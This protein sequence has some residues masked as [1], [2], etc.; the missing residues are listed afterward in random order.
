M[1][2][3]D[4]RAVVTGG[5]QGIGKGIAIALAEE[6]A[7]IIIQYRNSQEQALGTIEDLKKLGRNA[8]AIQSDFT[9][10]SA[11]E[12][13]IATALKEFGALD[14]LVNCAAAYDRS[15]L[16]ELTHE[17]LAWMHK[18]NVEIPLRLI[19]S[20]SQH[21]IKRKLP[22]SIINISSIAG[23]KPNIGS[24]LIS[25]S[26][27]ALDMLTKCAALE[28]ASYQI[29]VNGIAPGM[30]DTESN[31]CYKETNPIGWQHA[32]DRIPLQRIGQPSDYAG[33][34]VFLA[35]EE[36]SWL[37]GVTINCDGGQLLG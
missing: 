24:T 23:F 28:L 19:Q 33:L 26:K 30:T 1:K 3:K 20:I 8:I 14:I 11:P 10:E 18:M 4:K 6:G 7:D 17:K 22:G 5:G 9:H 25:C 13:F 31:Q 34:A 32:I 21:F 27:A 16:L 12:K 29:R 35:S 2:L 15:P 36:S 37:T